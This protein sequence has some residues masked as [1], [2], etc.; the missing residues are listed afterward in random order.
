MIE[1][2]SHKMV[3]GPIEKL[4]HKEI[5]IAIKAMKP[6]RQLDLLKYVQKTIT[7]S[8]ELGISVMI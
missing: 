2:I 6:G 8:G 1:I 4:T 7:A 3:E 5:I